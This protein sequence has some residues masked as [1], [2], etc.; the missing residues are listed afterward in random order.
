MAILDAVTVLSLDPSKPEVI[1]CGVE[2]GPILKLKLITRDSYIFIYKAHN[3][4]V[5][6][7]SHNR[8]IPQIFLSCSADWTVKMWEDERRYVNIFEVGNYLSYLKR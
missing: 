1:L 4:M 5:H 8:F 3:L 2:E 7:I 6:A